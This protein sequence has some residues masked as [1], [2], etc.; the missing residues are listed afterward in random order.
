MLA[1][2]VLG[3]NFELGTVYDAVRDETI[4]GKQNKRTLAGSA[5]RYYVLVLLDFIQ[6]IINQFG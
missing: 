6:L 2:P 3:R 1:M 4:P 5:C